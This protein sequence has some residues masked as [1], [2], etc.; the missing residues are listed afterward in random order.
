MTQIIGAICEKAEQVIAVSDRMISM[1]DMEITYEKSDSTKAIV[2]SDKAV[3]LVAGDLLEVTFIRELKAAITQSKTIKDTAGILASGYRTA[4]EQRVVERILS[5]LLGIQSIAELHTKHRSLEP[6]I[7][8]DAHRQM[9]DYSLGLELILVGYDTQ[10][11]LFQISN[12]GTFYN[13]G[14][15]GF[16]CCGIGSFHAVATF[17][18]YGYTQTFGQ[19]DALYVAVEAKKNAERAAGVGQ[20]TDALIIDSGTIKLVRSETLKALEQVYTRHQTGRKLPTELDNE[21]QEITI[22]THAVPP[23]IHDRL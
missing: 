6:G 3:L 8:R 20:I 10:A 1:S 12:P 18:R 13:F 14:M 9:A 22:K 17:A 23:S 19:T 11:E 16:C 21:L 7:L 15:E 5:P 2:L 4:R